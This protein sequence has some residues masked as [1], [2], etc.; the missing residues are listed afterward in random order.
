MNK[1]PHYETPEMILLELSEDDIISTSNNI[2]E[3]EGEN[4]GEWA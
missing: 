3:D 2:G 1:T 4:D